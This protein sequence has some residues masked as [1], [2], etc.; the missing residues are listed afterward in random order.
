MRLKIVS[1][2][3]EHGLIN[4][5]DSRH[6]CKM[7]SSKKLNLQG[8]FGRCLSIWGPLPSYIFVWGLA[9]PSHTLFVYTVLWHRE[10]GEGGEVNQKKWPVKGALPQVFIRVYRL[11]IQSVMVVFSIQSFELLPLSLPLW[12]NSSPCPP[13]PLWISI[14]YIP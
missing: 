4:Y 5:V 1:D 8:L 9:N 3:K 7:S 6:Q 12:F 13:L 14:L 10:G 2:D 11:Q